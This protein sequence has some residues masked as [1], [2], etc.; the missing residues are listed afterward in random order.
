MKYERVGDAE[1]SDQHGFTLIET[2]VVIAIIAILIG[3]LLPAVQKVR[4]KSNRNCAADYLVQIRQAEKNHFTQRRVF[5]PSLDSL[6]MESQ[7]CGY[8][9]TVAVGA[10]AQSFIVNAIP[11]APGVTASEDGRI[12]QTDK[13]PVWKLNPQA[14]EGRR[15]MFAA[16][17]SSVPSLITS[18]RR[19]IPNSSGELVRGL[20]SEN[21]ASDAFKRLDGDSDGIV[22]LA[23]IVKGREDKTGALNEFIPM[24]RQRMRLG[25]AGE[26]ITSV[27]GVN[28][29]A[30]KHPAKFSENEIRKLIR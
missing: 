3:M 17:E 20:Q 28:F 30:L 2:L 12:D 6:G 14:D 10:K 7:K 29:E 8:G 11:A 13:S 23:E 26:N 1:E 5:T 4:E 16:L 25:L 27:P 19:K 18:V 15:R 21:S 24:I 22:T 9:Y